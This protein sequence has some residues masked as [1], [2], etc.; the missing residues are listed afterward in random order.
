MRIAEYVD[1]SEHHGDLRRWFLGSRIEVLEM[2]AEEQGRVEAMKS[3]REAAMLERC[4]WVARCV[5]WRWG[6]MVML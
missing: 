4:V 1:S 5:G 3:R 6:C 2:L